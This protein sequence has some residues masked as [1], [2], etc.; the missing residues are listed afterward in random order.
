[1]D[2]KSEGSKGA[3]V[4]GI[5]TGFKVTVTKNGPYLVSGSLP[6]KKEIIVA[7]E[8]GESVS[9]QDGEKYP[10]QEQ[11][12]LCSCGKSGNKPF[13]DGTHAEIGYQGAETAARTPHQE[14]ASVFDGPE[15][16]L[17]DVQELCAA[18]RF[19]HPNGGTWK[20]TRR[21]DDPEAKKQAIQETGDC[22]SGRLVIR[23][24]KTG[25]PIEPA[26][27][28]SISL[29]ED[30]PE[31][32]SGPIWLQGNIPLESSDGTSY[33]T[34]NRVTLCRC[35]G[36]GNKPFCDGT[37]CLNGFDDGDKSLR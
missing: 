7:D 19:C 16:V 34:R 15:L 33:E 23:D 4:D 26:F 13:C 11:Y 12:A 37:H 8:D 27:E 6:L 18:A 28:P 9:W 1:M 14:Q 32:A 2:I 30:P 3:A 22:P 24:K 20:L 36:S 21:S 35:G 10:D 5:K 25:R 31:K 29:I 17:N